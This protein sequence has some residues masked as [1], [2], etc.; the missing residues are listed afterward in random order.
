MRSFVT[1]AGMH[2]TGAGTMMSMTS[3]TLRSGMD[4]SG[5]MGGGGKAEAEAALL[6]ACRSATLARK[7]PSSQ[8]GSVA[9][10][11][12]SMQHGTSSGAPSR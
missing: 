8:L 12:M 6:A 9:S 3:V 7:Q 5:M 2:S 4:M 11:S 10:P 1:N